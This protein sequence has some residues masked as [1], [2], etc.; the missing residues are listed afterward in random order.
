MQAPQQRRAK[1]ALEAVQ[2]AIADKVSQ[3]EY[4]SYASALPAMIRMNGLGQAAAFYRSKG[5]GGDA[6]A[7]A[8]Q[9]LYQLLSDWLCQSDAS[10]GGHTDLLAGITASDLRTYQA[11]QAEALALLDW[12]KKFAK[13][14]MKEDGE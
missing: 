4:R 2:K 1:F 3:K 7:I 10:Y 8:Y 14:F 9:R 5:A 6:K 12:A 11:A 13:A